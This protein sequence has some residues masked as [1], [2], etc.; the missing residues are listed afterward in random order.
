MKE[1]AFPTLLHNGKQFALRQHVSRHSRH[2]VH[3]I[4]RLIREGK[5]AV[6][7]ID[8][9]VY[10]ELEE[11]LTALAACRYQPISSILKEK[12]DLFA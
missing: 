1:Y 4:N 2:A 10:V 3:T 11:A 12:S 8:L 6:T 7:L 5:I 9:Q